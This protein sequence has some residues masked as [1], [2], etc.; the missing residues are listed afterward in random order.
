MS[1]DWIHVA[2]NIVAYR[3]VAKKWLCEHQP[4]L[5]NARNAIIEEV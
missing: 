1:E 3:P 4:L 2:Q 5:G